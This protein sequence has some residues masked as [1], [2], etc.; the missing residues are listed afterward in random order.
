VKK[1]L[2]TGGAGFIGS[3]FIEMLLEYKSE[4]MVFNLDK[5]TYAGKK[6]NMP[7][8]NNSRHR[9][10]EGDICDHDLIS[11]LFKTHNFDIVVNFA[12]ESHVDNSINDPSIFINTNINGVVNLLNVAKHYWQDYSKHLFIQISTDEVYGSLG[13]TGKFTED[14]KIKPN[15]PYSSSKAASDLIGLSFYHT[16]DFPI[17]ITRSSNNFG[18]RQDIEKLIPKTITNALS[19]K[20]IP[21]YGDG[22]NIRDWIY[23]KDNCYA[24]L[25]LLEVGKAG[26]VYN[27]GGSNEKSNIQIIDLILTKI[28]YGKEL[29][30][31]VKDRPGHD[32]RYAIDDS[33]TIS[34][35]GNYINSNFQLTISD[36]IQYYQNEMK[37][38]IE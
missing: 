16:Y 15:S 22:K 35:I 24:I 34:I 19:G 37:D 10:I 23:V 20:T 11:E 32:F 6:E 33:K 3:H 4:V 9:F 36:T 17:I 27:V 8:F 26:E 25:K 2:V 14:S 7:F 1:Y 31:F 38:N 30:K 18:P 13:K 29:V 28:G 21:V 5:L 12:A